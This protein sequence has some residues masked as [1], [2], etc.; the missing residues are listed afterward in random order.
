MAD[1]TLVIGNKNL[2]SWSLRPWLMAKAAGIPFREVLVRLDVR[3]TRENILR[4]SPS[5]LV[6]A[7]KDGDLV[8]NDSLAIIEYLNEL[9]PAKGIW[10]EDSHA[11]A[12]ARA[13]AAEMHAGFSQLRGTWPMDVIHEHKGLTCPPGVARD[14]GRIETL[15]SGARRSHGRGGPFLFGTFCAADAM[16]APVVSRIRTYGP[17]RA[18]EKHTDYMEAVWDHPAMKEWRE[19]AK[20]E[21]AQGWYA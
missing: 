20:E 15:W 19:G 4:H 21:E 9:H 3:D 8:V 16:F 18:F 6:P 10:P 12:L 1:L 17:V 11:R 2:S 5:G 13:M 14:L 7:L